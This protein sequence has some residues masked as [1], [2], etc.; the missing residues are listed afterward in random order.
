MVSHSAA[1]TRS[2]HDVGWL[3]HDGHAAASRSSRMRLSSTP[4]RY[5]PIAP[6]ER[7]T[8]WHGTTTGNGLVAQADPTAR[9]ARGLP[10][11]SRDRGVA[12]GVSVFDEGQVRAAPCC[13]SRATGASPARCRRCCDAGEVL[14]E[15]ACGLLEPGGR[16]KDARADPVGQCLQ[17]SV[18]VLAGVGDA[19]QAELGCGQQQ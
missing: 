1:P 13:E 18:V 11:S 7:T 17:D 6:S 8:R 16:S 19:N 9:T 14:V 15:L 2:A 12:G 3:V 10:A 5:P 4:P